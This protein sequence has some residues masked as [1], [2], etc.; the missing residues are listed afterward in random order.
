MVLFS[1]RFALFTFIECLGSSI[2]L[3][4]EIPCIMGSRVQ[5][6]IYVRNANKEYA[7]L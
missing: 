3:V 1:H 2:A 4:G 7:G 5:F 6:K